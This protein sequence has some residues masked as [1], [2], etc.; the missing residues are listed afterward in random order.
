MNWKPGRPMRSK[1]MWSVLPV[2]RVATVVA[3][4]SWNGASQASKIG[5]AARFSWA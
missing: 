3:P 5:I 1:L 4:T 2:L